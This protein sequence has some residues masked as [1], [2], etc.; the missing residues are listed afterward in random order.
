MRAGSDHPDTPSAVTT[1][2]IG[3]IGMPSLAGRLKPAPPLQWQCWNPT[4]EREMRK[5]RALRGRATLPRLSAQGTTTV[6]YF[7]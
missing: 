7:G 3:L 2:K 5:V 6:T 4:S 1:L